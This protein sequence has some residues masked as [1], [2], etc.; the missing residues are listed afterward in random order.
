MISFTLGAHAADRWR[1][2][3][4]KRV[5]SRPPY[6]IPPGGSA[7]SRAFARS[8][9]VSLSLLVFASAAHA[10]WA[11]NGAPVATATGQEAEACSV[12]DG[13]GGVIVAWVDDRL[14]LNKDIYVQK[15]N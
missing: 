10:Q 7:M 1:S 3:P 15:L 5:T 12:A 13:S 8:V 14:S 11:L 9:C 4:V 2:T 6:Y